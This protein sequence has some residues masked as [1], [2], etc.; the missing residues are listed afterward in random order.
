MAVKINNGKIALDRNALS[1]LDLLIAGMSYMAPGYCLFFTTAVIAGFAG[2]HIPLIFLFAGLGILCTGTALAQLSTIAPSAGSLQVFID[3]GF[4]RIASNTCG[5]ILVV[6][7]LLLQVAGSVLLGG[8]TATLLQEYLGVSLPWPILAVI[9]VAVCTCLMIVGVGLSIRATWVLFLVEFAIVLII[10]CA[11]LFQGGASGL[12]YEPFD[13]E[14]LTALPPSAIAFG[15]VFATY[16]FVG[17][18]G[19]IAFAEETAEPKRSLPIA[20]I[21]G[22]VVIAL[23]YILATYS[24]VVGFGVDKID[25]VAKDPEP[26]STLTRM[27]A[28]PLVGLLKLAIWTSIIASFLAAGNANARI[29]FN[30]GRERMLP[31]VLGYVHPRFQTPVVALVTSMALTAAIAPLAALFWD[32]LAGFGNIAGLGALLVLLIYMIATVALPAH[33]LRSGQ[34][35]AKRPLSYVVIPVLGAAIWLFPLWGVLQPGQPFPFSIYPAV[36]FVL[37]VLAIAIALFR[38]NKLAKPAT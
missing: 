36:T 14:S 20:V 27:Y 18:E 24:V 38:R 16:S 8:W 21:G 29:L 34:S 15:I 7:Y 11:T 31:E 30:M 33:V 28:R 3:R 23:L 37:I 13:F 32:H 35:L 5:L 22:I 1:V 19:A 12:A 10:S 25:H 17:F 4:G 6:G 9:S 26:I 2:V